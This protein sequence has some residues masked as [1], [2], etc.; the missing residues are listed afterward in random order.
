MLFGNFAQIR[1]RRRDRTSFPSAHSQDLNLSLR[2]CLGVLRIAFVSILKSRVQS[3][4]RKEN[5]AKFFS[6]DSCGKQRSQRL[7]SG[8]PSGGEEIRR[9]AS[10]RPKGSNLVEGI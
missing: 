10:S 7:C 6:I 8:V 1:D 4:N 9:R 2:K 3:L 5:N